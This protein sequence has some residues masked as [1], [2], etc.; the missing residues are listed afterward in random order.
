MIRSMTAFA[1]IERKHDFGTLT[2]E[3]RSVNHRYLDIGLRLPEDLRGID[4]AV[5]EKIS[6]RCKRGKIDCS[7]R[8]KPETG[9]KNE[10]IQVDMDMASAV[11]EACRQIETLIRGG[12]ALRAIDVLNWPGVVKEAEKD[13]TPIEAVA[14]EQLDQA[15]DELLATRER[16]GER[17]AAQ[18]LERCDT[19]A[20]LVADVRKRRPDVLDY[21]RNKVESKLAEMQV[22]ID[23]ER[24]E[25]ELVIVAQRMDVAEELDRL[26]TH[27]TEMRNVLD[28]D[29]PVGRRLDFLMQELNREANTLGS[30]SA[31]A[32]TTKAAVDL[33]VLIEQMREQVQNIE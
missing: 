8:Y 22:N 3:L 17:T 13:Y 32:Q 12:P 11:V 9:V 29:E 33:K 19:I 7:L 2:W 16:E 23:R 18:L 5:R 15:L 26:D 20:G 27:I 30:K 21:I 4:Q 14:L 24:L 28:S 10:K 25:Q 6:T 1:R 31:D